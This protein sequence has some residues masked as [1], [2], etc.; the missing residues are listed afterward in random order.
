MEIVTTVILA[1]SIAAVCFVI[2]M[3]IA[4]EIKI[5]KGSQMGVPSIKPLRPAPPMPGQSNAK[6]LEGR[7]P[8]PPPIKRQCN[9]RG[10]RAPNNHYFNGNGEL[11]TDAGDL[12]VDMFIIATLCGEQ[13]D[14]VEE[15]PAVLEAVGS[16]TIA[17]RPVEAEVSPDTNSGEDTTRHS[18]PEPSYGGDSS[19]DS[20]DGGDDGG[21]D[22]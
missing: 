11:F 2:G 3:F 1:A 14:G 17:S 16:E 19:Y 8:P 21:D 13:Y 4:N 9:K 18:S 22:D 7:I 12:I 6:W 20:D 5:N 15:T 10:W